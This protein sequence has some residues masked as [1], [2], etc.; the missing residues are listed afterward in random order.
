MNAYCKNELT[1]E[2]NC[3]L[4]NPA[5]NLKPKKNRVLATNS[6]LLIPLSLQP[7]SVNLWYFKLILFDPIEFIDLNI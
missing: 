6:S 5:S 1:E 2:F 3:K 7:G 4:L